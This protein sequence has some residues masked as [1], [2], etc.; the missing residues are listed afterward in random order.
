MSGKR[1]IT[2]SSDSRLSQYLGGSSDFIP[3][4]VPTLRE[5]LRRVLHLQNAVPVKSN[6]SIK[7]IISVVSDELLQLWRR[8]NSYFTP[9]VVVYKKSVFDRLIRAY[10]FFHWHVL[11]GKVGHRL[12]T[13]R[14]IKLP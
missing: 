12:V 2:R 3:I 7:S 4:E 14:A 11:P 13:E 10:E 5:C 1:W 9:P 6:T 8:A